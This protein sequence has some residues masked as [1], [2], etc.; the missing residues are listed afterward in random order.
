MAANHSRF[1]DG[2]SSDD[3]RWIVFVTGA[4]A[5]GKTVTAQYLANKLHAKYIEG[6]DFHPKANIDKMSRGEGLT[7]ADRAGWL[8]AISEHAVVH[9]RGPGTHHLIVT[10]SALKR[11]YRAL[12]REGARRAGDLRLLFLFLDVPEAELVRRATARTNHYAKGNLVHS[13]V[14]ILERPNPQD[15]PDVVTIDGNRPMAAVE[16]SALE[17]V[18]RAWD[19]EPQ[20]G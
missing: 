18:H 17:A 16:Q 2:G 11:S 19:D 9:L 4:T 12:L 14:A 13:Q 15:E 8:E 5:C 3:T 20:E 10:C 6:D 1:S 7:D